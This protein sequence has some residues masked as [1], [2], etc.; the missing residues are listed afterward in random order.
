[1]YS[2][3]SVRDKIST[4]G[5]FGR[6]GSLP[7]N[8]QRRS[9]TSA[10]FVSQALRVPGTLNSVATAALS[11]QRNASGLF[12]RAIERFPAN[13]IEAACGHDSLAIGVGAASLN[14]PVPLH[15]SFLAGMIQRGNGTSN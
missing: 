6:G 11:S 2:P 12:V 3:R 4:R 15:Q 9:R 10:R 8:C 5:I 13:P 1:M 14:E 7:S